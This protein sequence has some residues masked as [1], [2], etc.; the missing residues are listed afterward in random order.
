MFN[1]FRL[2]P[3]DETSFDIVAAKLLP[4]TAAPSKQLLTLSKE[5]FDLWVAYDN[6]ASTLL[7]VWTGLKNVVR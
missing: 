2:C 3:K 1:L 7:L 6:V 5:S 4:K